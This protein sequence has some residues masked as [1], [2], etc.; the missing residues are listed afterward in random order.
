MV[1]L[2]VGEAQMCATAHNALSV[3]N[4]TDTATRTVTRNGVTTKWM[5]YKALSDLGWTQER[6][7]KAKGCSQPSVKFF[8][9]FA[10][11]PQSILNIFSTSNF[12]KDGQATF[13]VLLHHTLWP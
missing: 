6:I 2:P 8:L 10:D 13:L 5:S 3:A 12:L 4:A 11:F 1:C 9:S 7:A